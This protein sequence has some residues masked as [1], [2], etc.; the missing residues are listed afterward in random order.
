MHTF[1]R[2]TSMHRTDIRRACGFTLVEVLMAVFVLAVALAGTM[3]LH[4]S[5][6]RAQRQSSYHGI[7]L[8][9]AGDMAEIRIRDT[10][11]GIPEEVRAR[12]FDPFFTTKTVGRGTGQGLAIVHNAIVERHRGTIAFETELGKG[13]VFILRIPMGRPVQT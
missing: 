6:L 2:F 11:T 12:I 8:Q 3:H 10:G 9:L 1:I 5:A 4:L 13:T 7:A